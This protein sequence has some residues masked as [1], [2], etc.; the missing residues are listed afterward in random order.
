[1][2]YVN[3]RIETKTKNNVNKILKKL[4]ITPTQAITMYYKQIEREEGIP[5]D[6]K[7]NNNSFYHTHV[8]FNDKELMEAI[9]EAEDIEK[10]PEKYKHYRTIKEL[11]EDLHDFREVDITE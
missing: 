7:L 1:M 9:K 3:V 4:G 6:L 8:D 5:F 2:S 10:H 11:L